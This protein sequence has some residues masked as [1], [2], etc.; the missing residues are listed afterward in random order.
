MSSP[1][2]ADD[3]PGET[4]SPGAD[5]GTSIMTRPPRAAKR[6]DPPSGSRPP[7]RPPGLRTPRRPGPAS[8]MFLIPCVIN[9]AMLIY[10]LTGFRSHVGTED[11]AGGSDAD[12]PLRLPH[13]VRGTVACVGRLVTESADG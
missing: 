2:S 7:P 10:F 13:T 8:P 5:P 11:R 9:G 12:L 6:R 4:T 3:V 1:M